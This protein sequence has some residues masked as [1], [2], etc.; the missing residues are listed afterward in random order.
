MYIY[1]YIYVYI[2]KEQKT[3]RRHIIFLIFDSV[4]SKDHGYGMDRTLLQICLNAN[5][6]DLRTLM[7]SC[8]MNNEEFYQLYV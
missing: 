3:Q 5:V 1:I 8:T 6:D 2:L 4:N 7:D